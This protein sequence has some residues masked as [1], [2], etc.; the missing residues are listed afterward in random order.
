L[1]LYKSILEVPFGSVEVCSVSG[2]LEQ[3]ELVAHPA[4]PKGMHMTSRKLIFLFV[5]TMFFFTAC[6]QT[7]APDGAAPPQLAVANNETCPNGTDGWTK[8]DAGSGSA[9]GE[10]GNFSYSAETLTYALNPGYTLEFCIKSGANA[11]TTYYERA[12][13]GT[14]SIVQDISHVSWRVV[15]TPPLLKKLVDLKVSK[16]AETT[17]T[18]EIDWDLTKTVNGTDSVA[19]SGKPGNEFLV[20]WKVVGTKTKDELRDFHVTG[21]ITIE[22]ENPVPVTVT[23]DDV[24]NDSTV[25]NVTCPSSTVAAKGSLECTYTA[26]P[27]SKAATLN[28]VKVTVDQA[29]YTVPA[30]Y[31]G[32]I[33]G[34]TATADVKWGDPVLVGDPNPLL[35]DLRPIFNYSRNISDTTI[36]EQT[37]TF[38]CPQYSE[39]LYPGDVYSATETNTSTL[40]GNNLDKSASAKV[41]LTCKVTWVN[42]TATGKGYKWSSI[43]GAP[44][45]WF[46]YTA[47]T[48]EKVDL[49]AG[50]YYDAGDV[51]MTR[52]GTTSITIALHDGF[53]FANVT[54]NVKIHPMSTPTSY[55]QPGQYSIKR[56]ASGR[57]ITVTGL[58][59]KDF[60]AIHVDVQRLVP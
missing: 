4:D 1:N 26:S 2:R 9:T 6:N 15:G 23:V 37:E 53:R 58:T 29:S 42:E 11:G 51:T 40:T 59:N 54:N 12:G 60:Y 3:M 20:D 44:S 14:I 16:G 25:A 27:V 46:M 38:T 39:A 41:D 35:E 5:A 21:K 48:L 8:I 10:F 36:L 55:V 31:T 43:R 45:N 52:N 13:S 49:I 32:K 30:G 34:G 47:F 19:F 24:L 22:N 28:T 7:P 56:T 18:R 50:Q 57:S 33:E 17:Y